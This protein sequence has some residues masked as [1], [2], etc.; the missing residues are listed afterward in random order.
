MKSLPPTL[1]LQNNHD[2][3]FSW[4]L[5]VVVYLCTSKYI[6]MCYIIYLCIYI[7]MHIICVFL[8]FTCRKLSAVAH[9]NLLNYF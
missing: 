3:S 8:K 1:S 6:S 5:S 2:L 7:H 4:N 9:M